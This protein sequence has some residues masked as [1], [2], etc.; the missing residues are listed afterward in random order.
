MWGVRNA[1][2]QGK[3]RFFLTVSDTRHRCID[4]YAQYAAPLVLSLLHKGFGKGPV[5]AH[6]QLKPQ[7]PGS[8]G[9]H[10]RQG[11]GGKGTDYVSRFGGPGSTGRCEFPFRVHQFM[12]RR[13]RN[14]NG[15]G[16]LLPEQRNA[17]INPAHVG[18]D[19]WVELQAVQGLPVPAEG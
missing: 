9:G 10:C 18:Q 7:G 8:H 19:R 17:G 13:W 1:V 11:R 16:H 5:I 15:I 2:G 3:P 14:Q 6:V 4:R 12:I